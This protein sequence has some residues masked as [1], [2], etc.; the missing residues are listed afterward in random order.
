MGKN[1]VKICMMMLALLACTAKETQITVEMSSTAFPSE[2]S[3]FVL[4]I[5]SSSPWS[6]SFDDWWITFSRNSGPAGKSEVKGAV[7]ANTALKERK[8]VITVTSGDKV[9]KIT[10]TQSG[11]TAFE[12]SK[13]FEYLPWTGGEVRVQVI[14]SSDYEVTVPEGCTWITKVVNEALGKDTHCFMIE[15]NKGTLVREE[16]ICFSSQ[17]QV[18]KLRI[19]QEKSPEPMISDLDEYKRS[20]EKKYLIVGYWGVGAESFS[21]VTRNSYAEMAAAGF[22]I[23]L[24]KRYSVEQVKTMLEASKNT[25][26]ELIVGPKDPYNDPEGTE[27]WLRQVKELDGIYAYY[28]RDEPPFDEL[29]KGLTEAY[30]RMRAVDPDKLIYVNLFGIGA[31]YQFIKTY[32]FDAYYETYLKIGIPLLSYDFYCI[33]YEDKRLVDRYF[34]TLDVC[35][36]KAVKYNVPCWTFVLSLNHGEFY[37]VNDAT[38]RFQAWNGIAYGSSAI[39]YFTY[40]H[41]DFAWGT[42]IL[43]KNYA[44]TEKYYYAQ[45]LNAEIQ[46]LADVFVGMNVKRVRGISR[47]ETGLP[48]L[49][50]GELPAPFKS[51]STTS[52]QGMLMSYFSNGDKEYV[53]I[54]NLDYNDPQTLNVEF[55]GERPTEFVTTTEYPSMFGT[56]AAVKSR[57]VPPG[58]M[59]LYRI[60]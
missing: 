29:E 56:R 3:E 12:L 46:G 60:K 36:R 40:E 52:P 51:I 57:E 9:E 44:K 21:S 45:R 23:S 16:D 17:G 34:E 22:N 4:T 15:E 10:V 32:D 20:G 26:I 27:D 24:A 18:L 58:D 33:K 55:D 28:L 53:M 43:D 8:D 14:S 50:A 42:A 30:K 11:A 6:I 2:A 1:M 19:M 7:K 54:V 31:R 48:A 47:S 38:L 39:Q 37:T 5:D 49:A 59:V 25:G 13:T 35:S 41:A